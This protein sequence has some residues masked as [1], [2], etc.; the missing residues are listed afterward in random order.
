MSRLRRD[1]RA[2]RQ[3]HRL[4]GNGRPRFDFGSTPTEA[5]NGG[6]PRRDPR[7]EIYGATVLSVPR[8]RLDHAN[9]SASPRIEHEEASPTPSAPAILRIEDPAGFI[10]VVPDAPAGH[11]TT[12]DRQLI[13]V[14]RSLADGAGFAVLVLSFAPIQALGRAGVDRAVYLDAGNSKSPA[15]RVAMLAAALEAFEPR[16]LLFPESAE[17]GDLARRLSTLTGDIL[18][19]QAESVTA[20]LATRAA[21]NRRVE[22]RGHPP[23]L[24]TVTSDAHLPYS[25]S[26]CEARNLPAPEYEPSLF[27]DPGI[28]SIEDLPIEA[29]S[30]PLGEADFVLSAGNGVTDFDQFRA[31]AKALGATP[32]A[33][34][35]VCDAGLMPREAQVGASGTVL[36]AN[37]YVALGISGAPQHLQ[38]IARCEHVVAINTDLHAAMVERAGLAIIADA[39]QVMPALIALL[40]TEKPA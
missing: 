3:A 22:Q 13:G 27:A 16:H 4:G 12:L 2:S 18:F 30:L 21:Q 14:A 23:R 34:R 29:S 6:R 40:S 31:L 37:C 8:R 32:G 15:A 20:T 28:L 5:R 10:A 25:G 1:P 33:S 9:H 35:M 24:L 38:G 36:E 11:L 7:H 19:T 26:E 17:G 39:Q